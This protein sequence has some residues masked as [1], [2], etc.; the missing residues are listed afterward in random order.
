M[1][2]Y[3]QN[4]PTFRPSL[5]NLHYLPQETPPPLT[6]NPQTLSTRDRNQT[7][8]SRHRVLSTPTKRPGGICPHRWDQVAG[9]TW[10]A[11]RRRPW[12]HSSS[13][14]GAKSSRRVSAALT[15]SSSRSWPSLSPSPPASSPP[16]PPPPPQSWCQSQRP[17]RQLHTR[18]VEERECTQCWQGWPLP[19][20]SPLL[21]RTLKS[22]SR[23]QIRDASGVSKVAAEAPTFSCSVIHY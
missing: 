10:T 22:V 6:T 16:A 17:S 19:H 4:R 2:N 9:E 21:F 11:S 12:R 18:G 3:K 13:P 8:S 5:T 20:C 15:G 7:A 1:H 14:S 23:L